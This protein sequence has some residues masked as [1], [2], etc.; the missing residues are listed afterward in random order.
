MLGASSLSD[1]ESKTGV[2]VLSRG[3]MATKL[4]RALS[5]RAVEALI[6]YEKKKAAESEA[7]SLV[8]NYSKPVFATVELKKQIGQP[9]VKPVRVKLPYSFFSPDENDDSICLFCR[10]EDKVAIVEFL[11]KNPVEGLSKIVSLNELK[12]DYLQ[13]QERKKLFKEHTH[14]LCDMRIVS[15]LN[16]LLGKTFLSRHSNMPV[17]IDFK[18][19]HGIPEAVTKS[20]SSSYMHLKGSNITI[21]LGTTIQSAS[22]VLENVE[23][24]LDFAINK[25]HG[26]WKDVKSI[27]LKTSD[28]PALPIYTKVQSESFVFMKNEAG[29]S[30]EKKTGEASSAVGDKSA[31]AAPK[32]GASGAGKGKGKGGRK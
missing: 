13:V 19:V 10:S 24:G 27:H 20:V 11:E 23:Q 7:K 28:S 1:A 31:A 30:A 29:K 12:K 9:V 22:E 18:N 32:K 26:S 15:H 16:N 6:A 25:L 21:K 17:P 4:D 3:A 8:G 5:T 14:F 2:P